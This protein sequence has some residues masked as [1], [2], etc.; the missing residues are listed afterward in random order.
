MEKNGAIS[1]DTPCEKPGCCRKLSNEK[2]AQL[3]FNFPADEKTADQLDGGLM[4]DAADAV[5]KATKK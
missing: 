4:K 5:N 2:L 1:Q 3:T